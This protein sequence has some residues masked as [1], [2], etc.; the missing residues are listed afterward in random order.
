MP[1]KRDVSHR[2]SGAEAPPTESPRRR[3]NQAKSANPVWHRLATRVQTQ[4]TVSEPGDAAEEEAEQVAETVMR[5]PAGLQPAITQRPQTRDLHRECADCAEEE[6]VQ[7]EAKGRAKS[8]ASAAV[9]HVQSE[10]GAPLP[11]STLRFMES[12]FGRGLGDVRI[13]TGEFAEQANE[14]LNANAFTLGRD[15][16][17]AR[18]QFEP[19]SRPGRKL[20]AHELTHVVQQGYA[21]TSAS[22]S[23]REASTVQR[24]PATT[25]A[26]TAPAAPK[27]ARRKSCDIN[28]SNP[29]IWFEH[30]STTLRTGGGINS[31]VH[32][33]RAI[34]RS[35]AHIAA[36]GGSA[37]VYLYGYASEEGS[38]DHNLDLSKRRASTIRSL[39]EAAGVPGSNLEAVGLGED[40]SMSTRPLNRR[41]V[42]CPTP[43]IQNITMPPLEIR[44]D[45][46]NCAAPRKAKNLTQYA[47]LVRCLEQHLAS[48]H[49]PVDILK[50]LREIYYGG[51]K[52]DSAACGDRESATVAALKKRALPLYTALKVSKVTAGVDV[53]HIFTGLEGMLCPRTKTSPA[54]YA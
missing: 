18:G 1:A 41:V 34:R 9:R 37:K 33:M 16:A 38:P 45:G 22:D 43:Q 13:H 19:D 5:S 27:V 21:G 25:S 14:A 30:N 4:L 31:T 53:G 40:S 49:G 35:Q 10:P 50:T 48:T 39:L 12:R 23:E 51:S 20:L 52:F 24:A 8:D 32:L 28:E 44:G 36:A 17:F 46:M 11:S 7:R 6:G 15:I 2:S 47:A 26:T 54:W 3:E 29:V 42:I